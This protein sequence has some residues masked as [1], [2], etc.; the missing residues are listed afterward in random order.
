METVERSLS[1]QIFTDEILKL[2]PM[3][4]LLQKVAQMAAMEAQLR[5]QVS[6]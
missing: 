5:P 3:V 4:L 1:G 6:S 2:M